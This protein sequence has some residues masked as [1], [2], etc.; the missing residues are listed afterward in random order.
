ML[1]TPMTYHAK[2][3]SPQDRTPADGISDYLD[4]F[5]LPAGSE[6]DPVFL[7]ASTWR[8]GSTLAQRMLVASGKLAMWGEPYDLSS[9][10][11][12]ITEMLAPITS[13]W[14]PAHYVRGAS[15]LSGEEWIANLYPPPESMVRA[16][17]SFMVE[18]F[19]APARDAGFDRWGLK[20]VRLDGAHA[21]A[22][23]LAFPQASLVMLVRNPYDAW[24]SYRG[25]KDQRARGKWW[26]HRWPDV[27]VDN[28]ALFGQ[29]WR[30]TTESFLATADAIGALLLPYEQLTEQTGIDRLAEHTGIEIA[31][32]VLDVRV[33]GSHENAE[34]AGLSYPELRDLRQVVDPT[35]AALGYEGPF[36]E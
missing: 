2:S 17:R 8:S 24:L 29:I 15:Q 20:E 25:L 12:R 3:A 10:V 7:L 23:R 28:P 33:G 18:L 16:I 11:Q 30:R 5:G 1:T 34:V 27:V 26:Y 9:P 36:D 6:D 14:P 35:A 22:L 21:T 4:R 19:A 32:D 31:N 13:E